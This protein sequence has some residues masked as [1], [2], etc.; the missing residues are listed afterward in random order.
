[1]KAQIVKF[2]KIIIPLGIGI[3]L[4]WYFWNG[5]DENE[6]NQ[7]VNAFSQANYFWVFLSLL[8]AFLSHLSRAYRW[9]FQLEPLGYKVSLW[10][11]YHAVMSGYVI[12]YTVPRSGEFARAGLLTTYE[13]VPFEKSFATIVVERVID[14]I[15]LGSIVFITGILQKDNEKFNE[16][17]QTDGSGSN[18]LIIYLLIAG[19]IFG[20][21][22]LLAMKISVKFRSFVLQKLSGFW[23]GLKTIWTMKKKWAYIIHTLFIWSCYVGMIWV[24]AQAFEETKDLP[25]GAIF[26]AFV[27]GAAAIAL[28]PGGI[29]A[30]PTWVNAVLVLYG[31]H[32]AAYGIF[33]WVTQTALIVIL[34]LISL[35]L[36][37]RQP[38][39]V[40][41]ET[42]K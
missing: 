16:I 21:L 5:L 17:T 35:L 18:S 6:K 30:Y 32:F 19:F 39:L 34:G 42:E 1:M 20:V 41:D 23:E 15:M 14:V 13:K 2:L 33:V 26:G 38:K 22:G 36:I 37:Q 4:T 7:T 28:L 27:V 10:N 40:I 25:I 9:R 11:A 31:I 29:G 24:S 3:Y 12:N 8:M